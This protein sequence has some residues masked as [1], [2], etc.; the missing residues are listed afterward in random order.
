MQTCRKCGAT[1]AFVSLMAIAKPQDF[2]LVQC[3]YCK[4]IDTIP[5]EVWY[6]IKKPATVEAKDIKLKEQK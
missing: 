4:R 3:P 6:D 5:Y 2:V 1:L